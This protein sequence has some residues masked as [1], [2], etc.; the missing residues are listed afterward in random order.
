MAHRGEVRRSAP[1]APTQAPLPAVAAPTLPATI[2]DQ[3][4]PEPARLPPADAGPVVTAVML[5]FEKQGG[6]PVI[7]ANTYLYYMQAEGQPS[8]AERVG[9]RSTTACSRSRSPTSSGCGRRTSSTTSSIEVHDV[10]YANGVLGKVVVYNMEERQRVKIVD[11][12]GP[13]KVDQ[14]K[15]EEELKKQSIRFGS[16]RSSIPASSGR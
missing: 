1:P 3:T 10:R 14:S 16:T 8:V 13:K 4:V 15:I 6:S 11:Y 12:V 5:C 7:E 9:A 2:C